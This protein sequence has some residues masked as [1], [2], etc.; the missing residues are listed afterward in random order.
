MTLIVA[1][2]GFGK[3]QLLASWI[4]THAD[5]ATAWVSLDPGDG[6]PR[7]FWTY[8]AH[9]VDRVRSGMAR[10]A[11]ARLTT[12]GVPV[13]E[14][15]DELMNGIATFAGTLVIAVDD[16][17][18]FAGTG[19]A[20]SLPY[21]LDHLPPPARMVATTRSDP[22]IR[23]GRLR[24]LG[25]VVD[26]RADELVFTAPEARALIVDEM[27]I[28]LAD[29]ELDL[30]VERTEGWPAGLSLAGLWLTEL[31]DP[32]TSV[33][34]FSGDHR[35]VADYLVEEVL[36]ALDDET[37]GFL[38]QLSIFDRFSGPLCDAVLEAQGSRE[39]LEAL[40]QSNLFVISLDRRGGWYRFHQLFRDLLALEFSREDEASVRR[41]HERAAAW[42]V[43][44]DMPEEGLEHTAATGE[45]EAV[46]RL[47]G[48]QYLGLIRSSRV[49]LFLRWLDWLPKEVMTENPMLAAAGVLAVTIS[50][51]PT[52][53]R[54][55]RFL[56]L[57][58]A[59]APTKPPAVKRRV[60]IAADGARAVELA[61][62]VGECVESGRRAVELALEGDD[63]LVAG[64][65]SILAY[66]LYV[67]GADD[68]AAAVANA[69]LERPEAP[70]RPH[71]VIYALACRALVEAERGQIH[72]AEADARRAMELARRLGLAAVTAAGLARVAMGQVL[73]ALGDVPGAERNL[74]RAETL[75]RA[76]RP[77]LHHIHALLLLAQARV[78]SGHLQVASAELEMAR[79]ELIAFGDA[80]R[81]AELAERV[82]QSLADALATTTRP[83]ETPTAAELQVLRLLPTDLTLRQ[84]GDE[85]YLSHNTVKTHSRNLYRKLGAAN[86]Q[87]A[88][89]RAAEVGL[90]T[91]G[92]TA[93]PVSGVGRA[94]PA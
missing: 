54:A 21:A 17:H 71:A 28:R 19:A 59:G 69:A 32:G 88:V 64:V 18:H 41:L 45:P 60:A 62:D 29:D 11:L 66:A 14:A 83:V 49:D 46:A 10:P 55:A 16:L 42:F 72:G 4:E 53:E 77:T 33:R 34:S 87:E 84:I 39:R 26:I 91:S 24:S 70:E 86:R 35:Q 57:A 58:Q 23:L 5:L 40:A 7:R 9:A 47:L 85:L 13:E 67:Q 65:Q 78:A 61:T 12:P 90:L 22:V 31:D 80:G 3:T 30:L 20:V 15:I 8:V 25:A 74:E 52:D 89:R 38:V 36:D 93:S 73:L 94:S 68:E 6:D 76:S 50:G 92:T 37:R 51:Q 81:L 27:G 48:Q 82:T 75:R 79:E 1:P 63:E 44:H 56:Q 2:A 43:E